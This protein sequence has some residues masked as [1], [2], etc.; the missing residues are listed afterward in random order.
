MP[1]LRLKLARRIPFPTS[2]RSTW[3]SQ[4][5]QVIWVQQQVGPLS[6]FAL[7]SC[8]SPAAT[9]IIDPALAGEV[10]GHHDTRIVAILSPVAD[11]IFCHSLTV[12]SSS[13]AWST[14]AFKSRCFALFYVLRIAVPCPALQIRR[15]C[16]SAFAGDS[17]VDH[18]SEYARIASELRAAVT[19]KSPH[20][21]CCGISSL[22]S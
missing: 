20:P 14:I 4:T 18:P 5:R 19:V 15:V 1:A 21:S 9:S 17:F 6:E 10:A 12:F 11:W 3:S 16:P 2:G 7:F 13:N 22:L 8:F